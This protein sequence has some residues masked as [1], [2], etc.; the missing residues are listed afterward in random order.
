[1]KDEDT[2]LYKIIGKTVSIS[3]KYSTGDS[4]LKSY[5]LEVQF[6]SKETSEVGSYIGE[7]EIEDDAGEYYLPIRDEIKINIIDSIVDPDLCCRP[8][9]P[10]PSQIYP[11]SSVTPSVTPSA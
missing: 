11:S 10:K 7:F 8:N 1:M 4:P 2:D 5:F 3:E 9:R 6:T